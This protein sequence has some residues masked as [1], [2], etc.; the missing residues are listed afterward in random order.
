MSSK[1]SLMRFGRFA[2]LLALLATGFGCGSGGGGGDKSKG[3]PDTSPP[4]F[5]GLNGVSSDNDGNVVL[6]SPEATDDQTGAP[7]MS[8]L[9]YVATSPDGIQRNGTTPYTFT[10]ASACSNGQCA[11]TVTDLN[12]DGTTTYYFGSNAK[13]AAGHLDADAHPSEAALKAT[14]LVV[15]TQPIPGGNGGGD[16]GIVASSSLNSNAGLHA[17]HPSLAVADDQRYVIWEECIPA[18]PTGTPGWDNDHP[19]SI[20][21]ASQVN[22][23]KG[24]NWELLTDPALG[25]RTDISRDPARHSHN[26]TIAYDGTTLSAAWRERGTA[27][28]PASNL[29]VLN[30]DGAAWS[31]TG[32]PNAGADRP[33]LTR[34]PVLGTALGIGYELSPAGFSNRQLFFRQF[35]GSWQPSG[36]TLNKNPSL[37][38]EAPNFSK[39]GDTLYIAW[40][41][42]TQASAPSTPNIFVKRWNGSDWEDV[43]GGGALNMNA[44]NEA[45]FPSIDVLGN[46][47]YVAWHECF[48]TN[49]SREHI[50]VKH[51]DGSQWV[52]D[53][54][55]GAC[56]ADTTCGSLNVN[57]RFAKTP[58]LAVHNDKVYVA[59]SERDT[60]TNKFAVRIKRLDGTT[61]VPLTLPQGL[62]VNNAHS[63]VLISNGSLHIAWV[64]ENAQGVLQLIVAKLG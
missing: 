15:A 63:P 32:F 44:A 45:R 27:S 54:D 21:T 14:P 26:P 37:A 13:D 6:T 50:F 38:G 43:G 46:I 3:G 12:K 56:G 2:L 36:S 23:R 9:I 53:P 41:E 52:Q 25:G 39:K 55:T 18:L 31:D 61:W 10:G 11:F 59:W 17:V 60:V 48:D 20:D 47:P 42:A 30:F 16:G 24:A 40:K 1:T 62:F 29:F 34:H 19:C 28:N 51:F 49:C 58:S 35:N 8:Y 33:A 7:E 4:Q 22:I 5:T 64:E 57:S